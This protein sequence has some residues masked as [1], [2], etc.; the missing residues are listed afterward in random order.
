[1]T[2]RVE[3]ISSDLPNQVRKKEK[4]F[5]SIH[6]WVKLVTEAMLLRY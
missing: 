2:R 6:H 5:E 4:E 3:D 1:M